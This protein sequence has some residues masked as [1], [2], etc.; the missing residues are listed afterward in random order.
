M[1]Q[2]KVESQD[3]ELGADSPAS[4]PVKKTR[5]TYTAEYVAREQGVTVEQVLEANGNPKKTKGSHFVNKGKVVGILKAAKLAES[6]AK[7]EDDKAEPDIIDMNRSFFEEEKAPGVNYVLAEQEDGDSDTAVKVLASTMAGKLRIRL[8]PL[9]KLFGIEF[10]PDD[11]EA[12][13]FLMVDEAEAERLF[14][15]A[16]EF[17]AI[18]KAEAEADAKAKAKAKADAKAEAKAK[19]D[20]D[21]KAKADAEAKAAAEAKA[22]AESK[23][24]ADAEAK[25]EAQAVEVEA[26][27][28][29]ETEVEADDDQ[30]S[31]PYIVCGPKAEEPE[32]PETPQLDEPDETASEDTVFFDDE[33][34]NQFIEQIE[35]VIKQIQSP[36]QL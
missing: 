33:F 23:A 31:G 11:D 34:T 16:C 5:R 3:N 1:S 7:A 22:E 17:D 30:S 12:N 18:V 20:A 35:L 28:E 4:K 24:K 32:A 29:A 36:A 14:K 27:A 13:G 19:A 15:E 25:A 10:N 8:K 26:S 6:E 9:L 2:D 21:A